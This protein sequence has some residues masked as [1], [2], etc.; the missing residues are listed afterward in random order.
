MTSTR[1]WRTLEPG[2]DG[3]REIGRWL[4]ALR[5][6][7]RRTLEALDGLHDTHIDSS[8]IDGASSIGTLLYHLA[9]IEADWLYDDILGTQE[10]DWPVELFPVEHR[11]SAGVLTAFAGEALAQHVTRLEKVRT[12]LTNAIGKMS[13]DE[14]HT[15][16]A[17]ARYDVSPAWALHHL[18]QHEAEHRSQIGRA[19][20]TLEGKSTARS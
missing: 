6:T 18:M 12:L 15:P 7:R 14:L 2:G 4:M 9:L 13:I 3:D 8:P 11:D 1:D 16:R 17:R 19:R 5:D 20:E 10:T